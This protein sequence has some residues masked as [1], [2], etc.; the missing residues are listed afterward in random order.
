MDSSEG[1]TQVDVRFSPPEEWEL[2]K[3]EQ[4]ILVPAGSAAETRWLSSL[5]DF[6]NIFPLAMCYPK[7]VPVDEGISIVLYHREDE[8]LTRLM[9]TSEETNRLDK[10]WTELRYVSQD[11]LT[12]LVVLEQLIEFATQD[13]EPSSYDPL[14]EPYQKRAVEYRQW[15]LDTETAHLDA[16]IE[17]APRAYRRPLTDADKNSIRKLYADLRKQELHHE[18]AIRLTLARILTSP[19]FL[20]KLEEP[21]TGTTSSLVSDWELANRLSYF[22]WS[23]T[24]DAELSQL[25]AENK[26]H[27][28]EVLAAQTKRMLADPRTRRMAIE[29]GCQWLHIR[30]FDQHDEKSESH[31]PEFTALRGDMYEE[32]ILFFTDL[33][34]NDGSLLD[35][36]DADHTFLNENLARFYGIPNVEGDEW[37]RVDGV[38]QYQRGG[39]LTQATT[40]SKQSGAS[41]T[42]AILRGNWVYESL[43]G[44]RL[45]RPPKDV[46]VLP[47][48]V[49]EGL[50]EREL[51]EQ[52]S[53][54]ESCAKCHVR[55]DPF[56]FSLE[57]FD[58]IGRVRIQDAG[59]HTIDTNTQ[60]KD[61]TQIAGL[62]GL[63]TYLGETRRE[64]VVRQFCRK[65][66]GYAL[67]RSVQLSDEPLLNE[68]MT[69]LE[70]NDYHLSIAIDMIINSDQFQKIRGRDFISTLK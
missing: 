1:S 52:H 39:I 44:E 29:F 66:L 11:A 32:S 50:T 23:S 54:V 35:L 18:D 5:E 30:D 16:L 49:P 10:L 46:P 4:S 20:Y 12:S 53:S 48:D 24:P 22:L 40:L 28:P 13:G 67:G 58:A 31:F 51:I 61:G 38:R 34:Q 25:A 33:I 6:R 68:M 26:L 55:I 62:A 2:L 56:G 37:R 41:R 69:K 15:L 45:P 9:L 63:Q 21:A 42:S 7:I 43:L 57:G 14:R 17:F 8:P 36:I 60:L 64:T 70:Q 65:L 27:E 19:A 59:G 3:P 47:E